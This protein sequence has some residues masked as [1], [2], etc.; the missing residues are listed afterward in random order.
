[1]ALGVTSHVIVVAPCLGPVIVIT[2]TISPVI[3]IAT[4]ISPVIVVAP[5]TSHVIVVAPVQWLASCMQLV[6]VLVLV[7]AKPC[8]QSSRINVSSECMREFKP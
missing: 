1:M 2:T 8:H 6:L 3:V 5:V 7:I 4:A